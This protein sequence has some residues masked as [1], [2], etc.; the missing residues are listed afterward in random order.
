[1]KIAIVVPGRFHAFDLARELIKR[2]NEVVLFTNYLKWAVRRF[3]VPTECTRSFWPQGVAARVMNELHH[4]AGL[5][6]P[7][8]GLSRLF[9]RWAAN[10]LKSGD[11]DVGH[12]WSGVSEEVLLALQGLGTFKL[13]VRESSHMRFQTRLL[14]EEEQRAGMPVDRASEGMVRREEREYLLADRVRVSSRFAYD[15]FVVQGFP[16]EKLWILPPG[17]D[18]KTFHPSEQVIE[19]RCRRILTGKPLRVLYVGSVSLRKGLLDLAEIIEEL[20]G[21]RFQFQ[22]VG[23]MTREAKGLANRL[24]GKVEFLGKIPQSALPGFY[25]EADLFVFPTIEDSFAYVLAQAHTAG[26]PILATTNCGAS[27]FLKEGQTGW[28]LPIR[29]PQHFIKRLRWCDLHR[30]ELADRVQQV[31]QGFGIQTWNDV[32]RDF[33]AFCRQALAEGPFIGRDAAEGKS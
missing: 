21:A 14:E 19:S 15:S 5:P 4:R 22:I 12:C 11:W 26:L 10:M 16:P 13:L 1:M 2:G 7:E 33:E 29:S 31:Y 18:T 30:S 32:G 23:P 8:L 3:G 9:G 25:A 17:A 20:S 28:I 27:D 24:S 6:Y